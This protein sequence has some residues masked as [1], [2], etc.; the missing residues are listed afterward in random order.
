MAGTGRS[1]ALQSLLSSFK[2]KFKYAMT[3]MHVCLRAA[4][5]LF[6]S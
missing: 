2:H 4:S 1:Q 3:V 5:F 6:A